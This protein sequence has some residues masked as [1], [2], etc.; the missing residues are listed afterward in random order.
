MTR[1]R[2][3]SLR[4]FSLLILSAALVRSGLAA[5]A[6]R[7]K[8]D[9]WFVQSEKPKQRKLTQGIG[10]GET[11]DILAGVGFGRFEDLA[12]ARHSR[13]LIAHKL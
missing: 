2:T 13:L 10:G 11:R 5:Q 4:L 8:P 3:W 9:D 12:V 6:G 7:G 1:Q